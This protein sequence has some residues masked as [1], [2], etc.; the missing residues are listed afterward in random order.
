M[1]FPADSTIVRF[2]YAMPLEAQ[3]ATMTLR[4]AGAVS[5]CNQSPTRFVNGLTHDFFWRFFLSLSFKSGLS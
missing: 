5:A 3:S 2:T 1:R 4:T